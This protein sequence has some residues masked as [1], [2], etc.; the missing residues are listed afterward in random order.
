MA[1]VATAI[2]GRVPNLLVILSF[3]VHLDDRLSG[4]SLIDALNVGTFGDRV[5]ASRRL[6]R[7]CGT[8]A[9]T[10]DHIRRLTS[11]TIAHSSL[12]SWIMRFCASSRWPGRP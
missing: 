2:F 5:D 1:R 9:L 7:R 4:S 6:G 3:L 8:L 10:G 11:T 12:E